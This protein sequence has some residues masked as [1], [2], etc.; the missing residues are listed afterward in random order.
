[1]SDSKQLFMKLNKKY[2]AVAVIVLFI[3]VNS[4]ATAKL[5]FAV[6]F[7]ERLLKEVVT[8]YFKNNLNKAVKF[9]DIYI[10]YDGTIVISDF[11]VS[12]TSDF[13][14]NI[15]LIKS[16]KAVVKLRFLRLFTGTISIKGVDF[17]DSEINFI[18]KYGRSHVESFLVVFDPINFI[19][20]TQKNYDDFCIDFHRAKVFYRES[21]KIKQI[22]LELYKIDAEMIIDK[23]NFSYAVSGRIKPFQS[24]VIRKGDFNCQGAINVRTYDS[25]SH[26]LVVDN[27]DL[28]YFNEHILDY[29]LA[30]IALMGGISAN[31][32]I[33]K[34]KNILTV[35]GLVETGSLTIRS[36]AR[37]FNLISN[38]NV[39]LEL[40][41]TVNTAMNRYSVKQFKLS[42]DVISLTASGNYVRNDREDALA[43]TFKT[44]SID[45]E[46][47]SQNLTPLKDIEYGGTLQCDGN[48]SLDFKNS[49]A[50]AMRAKAVLDGFTVSKN[51]KGTIM[52][53]IEESFI[54]A[55]LDDTSIAID[56]NGRPLRSD[57]AVRSRTKVAGW[58]PF[59]SETEIT[60][61]SKKMNL[62]NLK[63]VF[64]YIADNVYA[65]AYED[66]RNALEKS[67]FLQRPLGKFMNY[68]TINL[69]SRFATVF[70]GKNR[71]SGM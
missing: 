39:D 18:K 57:I 43:I 23:N 32:Q 69:K 66:K 26:R 20:K 50:S 53:I 19:R 22:V 21:L 45:L 60:I 16:D 35:N 61:N 13:N 67:P 52:P 27:F 58:V 40:G 71:T 33:S 7:P 68:N 64:L 8:D 2:A 59:K 31:V 30:D 36:L 9:K 51:T 46:D 15:S 37:K 34:N 63:Y 56:I 12:I 44:N 48:I 11:N 55:S 5:F 54:K 62:D 70:Y 38:E 17:Y 29:K 42:D 24:D 4:M 49:K 47:L 3:I 6:V 14:D 65:S 1:M 10:D 28:T 41:M 25:Y